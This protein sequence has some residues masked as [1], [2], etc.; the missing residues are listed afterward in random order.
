MKNYESDELSDGSNS[1]SVDLHKFDN[2][3]DSIITF[4][5]EKEIIPSITLN[6]NKNTTNSDCFSRNIFEI[7][8]EKKTGS[9]Q[10][11]DSESKTCSQTSERIKENKDSIVFKNTKASKKITMRQDLKVKKLG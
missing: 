6:T 8:Y 9:F 2:L 7:A 11:L 5:D 3:D 1:S 10:I 4:N